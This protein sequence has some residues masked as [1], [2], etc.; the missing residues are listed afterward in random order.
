MLWAR[1]PLTHHWA[2]GYRV[3]ALAAIFA[4][5][6]WP[7]RSKEPSPPSGASTSAAAPPCAWESPD[8][9]SGAVR[10]PMVPPPGPGLKEH[11]QEWMR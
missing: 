3:D 8:A 1:A 4:A 11:S 2:W 9:D 5:R 7:P 6:A 10:P